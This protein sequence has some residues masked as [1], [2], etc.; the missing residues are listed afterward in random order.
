MRISLDWV[1]ELVNI[2]N[3]S[4]DEVVQKLTLGGFEVTFRPVCYAL[5]IEL[6]RCCKDFYC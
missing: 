4:L 1:K 5:G 6:I 2:E 3:I